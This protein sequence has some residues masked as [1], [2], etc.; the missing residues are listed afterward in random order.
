MC[1]SLLFSHLALNVL[2]WVIVRSLDMHTVDQLL[3]E[4]KVHQFD[5][6]FSVKQDIFGFHIPVGNALD[7]MQKLKNEDNLGGIETSGLWVKLLLS[8]EVRENFAAGAIV[9]L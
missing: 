3:R 5:M 8:P 9:E 1:R 4:T 2:N 7:I 6:P